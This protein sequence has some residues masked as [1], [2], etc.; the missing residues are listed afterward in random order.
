MGR[1]NEFYDKL[2]LGA[3]RRLCID[4]GVQV[5]YDRGA[6]FLAEG[7][8]CRTVGL[9]ESGYFK[10]VVKTSDGREAIAGFVFGGEF[11]ADFSN[12]FFAR[13][14]EV[15]I[16]AGSRCVVRE[17][18]FDAVRRLCELNSCELERVIMHTIFHTIYGR[19]LNLYRKSPKERYEHLVKAH[20][21]L[22]QDVP[23]REI[24]SYL[25]ISPIHL[26]RIRR[27]L[28]KE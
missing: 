7:E 18:E 9:I 15:S 19:F 2:E 5:C 22:L 16:V 10:Y 23:L 24:A 27:E 25:Q 20:P 3:L 4:D 13:Q 8:V 28:L 12:S 26:S 6:V 11:V 14:A 21:A 1:F 17:L